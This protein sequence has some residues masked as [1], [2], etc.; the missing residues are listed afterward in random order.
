[1]RTESRE[2]PIARGSNA[3]GTLVE[4]LTYRQLFKDS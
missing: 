3:K 4:G 2:S 1:M